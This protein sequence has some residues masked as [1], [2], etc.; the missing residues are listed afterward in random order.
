[1]RGFTLRLV[2]KCARRRRAEKLN[3]GKNNQTSKMIWGK[4][5]VPLEE[6]IPPM[7][8]E[9]HPRTRTP[10]AFKA[11]PPLYPLNVLSSCSIYQNLPSPK[12]KGEY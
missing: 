1:M 2:A 10:L 12:M 8:V 11:G 9:L 6:Y 5:F 3:L 7:H 4:I